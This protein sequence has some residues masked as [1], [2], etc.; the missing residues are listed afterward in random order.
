M[1]DTEIPA[2][3]EIT[4]NPESFGSEN[5]IPPA[6]IARPTRIGDAPDAAIALPRIDDVVTR[7]TVVE[8]YDTRSSALSTNPNTIGEMFMLPIAFTR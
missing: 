7:A 2:N 8:P 1:S 6:Q 3:L 4:Q 5:P